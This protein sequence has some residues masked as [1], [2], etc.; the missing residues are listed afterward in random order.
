MLSPSYGE[1]GSTGWNCSLNNEKDTQ[2]KD[3]A[4]EANQC[5][6]IDE[7]ASKCLPFR[8]EA[9]SVLIVVKKNKIFVED[10]FS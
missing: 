7:S 1:V 2:N 8:S 9:D 5:Y 6:H 3:E 4:Q 10:R